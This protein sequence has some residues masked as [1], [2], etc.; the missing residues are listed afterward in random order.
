M[1]SALFQC[2]G[3]TVPTSYAHR[4]WDHEEQLAYRGN[5]PNLS[6]RLDNLSH[7]LLQL[8]D[9]KASDLVRIA[10][11]VYA[12]D[13]CISR[14][15]PTDIY[16]EKWPRHFGM[17]I[18][19]TNP[20]IW[21]APE[22]R[23]SLI[24]SLGFLS[25]D[26]WDF[27]FTLAPQG[28]P[29]QLPLALDTESLLGLLGTP[30]SVVLFS[31]GTDS[32][33]AAIT[34]CRD[35]DKKPIL[36]SHRSSPRAHGRQLALVKE[37]RKYI[38][39]WNFPH[40]GLSVNRIGYDRG[41]TTQRTR[42]FLYA[43]IATAVASQLGIGSVIL[44]DNGITTIQPPIN[45]QLVGSLATRST[46]PKFIYRF[47]QM[48][49]S[50]FQIG[51]PAISNPF[52]YLTRPEVLSIL[53]IQSMQSL[54]QLTNSCAHSRRRPLI[55]PHCGVCS[56]C[57]ERRFATLA[58]GLEEHDLID[59][60][61]CDIFL[62]AIP[63][64]PARTLALS[65]IR[66]AITLQA[67]PDILQS[68]P[69]LYDCILPNDH[70]PRD[71]AIQITSLLKRHAA[72]VI[73]TMTEQVTGHNLVTEQLPDSCLVRLV[74]GGEH[75]ETTPSLGAAKRSSKPVT[76]FVSYSHADDDLRGEL[77]KH[78]STLTREGIINEWHDGAVIAGHDLTDEIVGHLNTAD[79]ILLL[80]SSDYIASDFCWRVEVREAI[81]R[82]K[83]GE[84]RVIPI[85]LRPVDWLSTSLRSL[86][87][88]PRD[89]KPVTD[90]HYWDSHDKAFVDIV[91]GVRAAVDELRAG[92][93]LLREE[94][95][96]AD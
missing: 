34:L 85:I 83:A 79:M 8:L 16:W 28:D 5:A 77:S 51:P 67:D 53:S 88:L 20:H 65:Y 26:H 18:P 68:H 23:S 84:C 69:H 49:H 7:N 75:L 55:S 39:E 30:D 10:A 89:G 64:G 6:L 31:G 1:T 91:R 62:Q 71:T 3:A 86:K 61:G 17:V 72:M 38:N 9:S 93:S 44:A 14:G 42:S 46:H 54:L 56:Q 74:G 52:L 11:Y 2:D 24:E 92:S 12:A 35:E 21:N 78:L 45:A 33:C 94:E 4:H 76:V 36:V 63:E 80:I 82:H 57:V 87:A 66:F 22:V 37:L 58:S 96:G 19:V 25:D 27:S 81:A 50:L 95:E 15:G 70:S 13:Q 43:S 90:S 41:E 47:N 60:Y 29:Q 73:K 59:N 40:I 32:L 48:T